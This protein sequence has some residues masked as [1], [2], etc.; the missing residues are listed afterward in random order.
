MCCATPWPRMTTFT[1][2]N[3]VLFMALQ[4]QSPAVTYRKPAGN[5][6]DGFML[7]VTMP[8]DEQT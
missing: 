3:R 6:S 8:A 1:L 7:L 4:K 2:S 5:I